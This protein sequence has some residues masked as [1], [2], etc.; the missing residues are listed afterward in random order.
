MMRNQTRSAFKTHLTFSLLL[1]FGCT[2]VVQPSLAQSQTWNNGPREKSQRYASAAQNQ[3]VMGKV[4]EAIILLRQGTASDPTDPL[5]FMLLGMSLNMKGSYQEALDALKKSYDLDNKAR[6]TY[7]TIG[8]A[9]YLSRRYDQAQGVW[10]KV[11]QGNPDIGQINTNIGYALIKKGNM[12]EAENRLRATAKSSHMAQTA[13]R[14]LMLANYLKGNFALA[15][16]VAQQATTNVP[17]KQIP[18][19]LAEIDFLEG[20]GIE[21]SKKL[22]QARNLKPNKKGAAKFS[23]VS[24]GYLPQHD[25]HFDPF[26]KDYFDNESLIEAR[27]LDLPKRESRRI[28]LAKKGNAEAA[29]SKIKDLLAQS[30]NDPYLTYQ[31]GLIRLAN[32]DYGQASKDFALVS[33]S[34]PDWNVADLYWCLSLFREGKVDEAKSSLANY[35]KANPGKPLAPVFAMIKTATQGLQTTAPNDGDTFTIPGG[36]SKPNK[37]D[38]GF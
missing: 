6:E 35:E 18:L 17:L 11:L 9:H 31:A 10:T 32:G 19:I 14:G 16:T 24:I 37:G 26:S 8:F 13:Y 2:S 38:A 29:L 27:F 23:M 1:A 28:S 30:P 34:V 20:H 5:P 3:L 25:F 21:A 4:E 22:S 36:S 12:D 15:K 7:L 33:R